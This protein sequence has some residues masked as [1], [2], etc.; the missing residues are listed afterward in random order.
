MAGRSETTRLPDP[1]RKIAKNAGQRFALATSGLRVLPDFLIIGAQ[2]AGTTSLYRYL[3]EHPN[4]ARVVMGKGVHYFDEN[5]G[6]GL[7]WYRGHFPTRSTAKRVHRRTKSPLVTGEG[8]PYYL[9]HPAVPGRVAQTLP[10]VRIVVMLRD[11]V[12]RAYSQYQHEKARGY[13][14]LAFTDALEAEAERLAGERERL[15]AD[16]ASESLSFQH[17]SY[18]TRGL[19]LDQLLTWAEHVPAARTLILGSEE[20]FAEPDTG[21]GR[22]LEFLGLSPRSLGTYG[23]H[24][25]RRYDDMPPAALERLIEQYREP[26]RRLFEYLGREFAW[27]A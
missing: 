1:V 5:Y 21:Y 23:K 10:Q 4:V 22:T 26:N 7:D 16:P 13:E 25:A 24:N 8:A 19:Y 11:P 15:L 27:R 20:F 17:H 12:E 3:V 9:L 6:R 18:A 14:S 2:R